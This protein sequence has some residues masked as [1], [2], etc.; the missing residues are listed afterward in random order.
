MWIPESAAEVERALEGEGLEETASF[1]GKR[2]L[3]KN[4]DIAVDVCAMTVQGGVLLY[5]AGENAD[6]TRL[7]EAHPFG[8][9]GQRERVSQIVQTGISEPP[10]IEMRALERD[11]STSEGYLVVH[12]PQSARAPHQV[13]LKGRHEGR[14]YGRDATGNRILSQLEV[15]QLYARR[16]RWERD[17]LDDVEEAALTQATAEALGEP[18]HSPFKPDFGHLSTWART[19]ADH[20]GASYAPREKAELSLG[21]AHDGTVTLLSRRVGDRV[22]SGA[23]L[24]RRALAFAGRLYRD[25]GYAGAVDAALIIRP[26]SGTF[27]A[28]RAEREDFERPYPTDEYRRSERAV[29]A[30]LADDPERV[31]RR[32]VI[33]LTDALVGRGFEPFHRAPRVPLS[34]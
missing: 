24:V 17:A 14:F 20:F 13:I 31:A 29:A 19:D 16:A 22:R 26:L 8:L 9:A 27:S 25:A 18:V 21:V 12:V 5:G 23:G 3:G 15:E 2:E 1:D 7:T 6:R 4:E 34:V 28:I 33:D 10:L 11:G 30:E 32:L